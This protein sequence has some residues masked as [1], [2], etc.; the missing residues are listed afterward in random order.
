MGQQ[1]QGISLSCNLA[2]GVTIEEEPL[3]EDS[4][5]KRAL[6]RSEEVPF[7]VNMSKYCRD[8]SDSCSVAAILCCKRS[9]IAYQ[10]E[11]VTTTFF[12]N[13]QQKED[14]KTNIDIE[15]RKTHTA[16]SMEVKLSVGSQTMDKNLDFGETAPARVAEDP[17]DAPSGTCFSS[18]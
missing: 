13:T 7:K 9:G 10:S 18:I 16:N 15:G 3:V 2:T 8:Y 6:V 12:N 17:N 14:K 4:S 1:L 11:N 5:A